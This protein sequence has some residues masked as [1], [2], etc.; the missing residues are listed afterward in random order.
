M[1]YCSIFPPHHP[2]AQLQ[3]CVLPCWWWWCYWQW[4]LADPHQTAWGGELLQVIKTDFWIGQTVIKKYMCCNE[5]LN[6]CGTKHSKMW[7]ITSARSVMFCSLHTLQR[8][9]SNKSLKAGHDEKQLESV[10]AFSL[11]KW[12]TTHDCVSL[13]QFNDLVIK[14]QRVFCPAL[15]LHDVGHLWVDH[16]QLSVYILLRHVLHVTRFTWLPLNPTH[17]SR[18][19]SFI[20]KKSFPS[21]KLHFK[22][23]KAWNGFCLTCVKL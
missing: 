9:I 10:T 8:T 16:C 15:E 13:L 17:T 21:F 19:L 4:L 1:V 23:Q 6:C 12:K 5:W 22:L 20:L 2:H 3:D 7:C 18:T 14:L 11:Y